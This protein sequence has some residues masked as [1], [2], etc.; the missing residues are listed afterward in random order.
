[1]SAIL[2]DR[3]TGEAAVEGTHISKAEILDESRVEIAALPYL[4]EDGIDHVLEAGVLEAA[5]LRLGQRR[6]DGEGDDDVVG[7]LGGAVA[8][9]VS[10]CHTCKQTCFSAETRAR[11]RPGAYIWLSA[12]PG[13]R[14]LRMEPMRSTA[15][16]AV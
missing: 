11:A 15:I 13:D 7:I 3:W 5:F 16:V 8:R 14:C 9:D 4:L 6:A 12:L 1:M 10:D 2:H